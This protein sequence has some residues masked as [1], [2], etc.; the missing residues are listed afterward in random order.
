MVKDY[1]SIKNELIKKTLIAKFRKAFNL[2]VLKEND[3]S[4]G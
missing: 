1:K 3:H 2:N 4:L